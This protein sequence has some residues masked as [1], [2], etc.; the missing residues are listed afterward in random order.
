[1]RCFNNVLWSCRDACS[2]NSRISHLSAFTLC[3][4]DVIGPIL[5]TILARCEALIGHVVL[6][7]TIKRLEHAKAL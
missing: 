4:Y 5:A 2:T 3:S 7:K 6:H 1:M